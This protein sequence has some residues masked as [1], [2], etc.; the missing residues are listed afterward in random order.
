MT[1]ASGAATIRDAEARRERAR[2]LFAAGRNAMQVARVLGV[3]QTTAIKYRMQLGL[4]PARP[5]RPRALILSDHGI[6]LRARR[7]ALGLTQL[8][9]GARAGIS[10]STISH[11]ESHRGVGVTQATAV[12][13]A[14]ALETTTSALNFED[15]QAVEES[16]RV[17]WR[18][19]LTTTHSVPPEHREALSRRRRQTISAGN[20]EIDQV[21]GERELVGTAE[22]ARLLKVDPVAVRQYVYRGLLRAELVEVDHVVKRLLIPRSEVERFREALVGAWRSGRHAPPD[23]LI[24]LYRGAAR[25]RWKLRLAPKPGRPSEFTDAEVTLVLKFRSSHPDWGTR[26]LGEAVGMSRG[27]VRRILDR[28]AAS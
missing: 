14:A 7:C 16:D 13:I 2:D 21:V 6:A 20:G 26:T 9:V 5:G 1:V 4:E 19:R 11:L 10:S 3:S 12:S 25:R 24:G 23:H 22:A 18:G 15:G 17:R 8:E 27:K 28:Y